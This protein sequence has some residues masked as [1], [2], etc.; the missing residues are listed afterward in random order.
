M[1]SIDELKAIAESRNLENKTLAIAY[2]KTLTALL[3]AN[4]LLVVG[5]AL[6]SLVAGA[7]I[8]VDQ[9]IISAQTSGVLALISGGLTLIH[10]KLG[11][12]HYQAECRRLL[13]FH[14]GVAEDYRNLVAIQDP[15]TLAKRVHDLNNEL[16]GALRSSPVMPFEW[17]MR[18]ANVYVRGSVGGISTAA[19]PSPR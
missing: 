7:T 1:A 5:A 12:E 6:L 11:C 4:L 2:A 9:Q 13:A 3:P 19:A 17:S 18:K 14:R 10:S 15:A 16:A 8:L